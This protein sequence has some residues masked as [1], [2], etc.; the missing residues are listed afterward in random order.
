M[1]A[2]MTMVIFLGMVLVAGP[3]DKLL[4]AIAVVESH[5]NDHAVNVKEAAVGRYQIRPGYIKEVNRIQRM[6]R[7]T[8]YE[9][10]DR[11][12][13]VKARQMVRIYL[14]FW[15]EQYKKTTGRVPT[16]EVY[17]KIHNGHAFWKKGPVCQ[18]NTQ[19]YWGKVVQ[20]L[21]K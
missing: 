19:R 15:G 17:A 4:D 13:P 9:Y 1:K 2:I 3:S 8:L 16:D 11:L 14:G 7:G 12:D 18:N 5:N 20:A 10:K 6:K 21:K